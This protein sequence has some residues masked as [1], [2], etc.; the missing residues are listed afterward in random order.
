MTKNRAG[1]ATAPN[2]PFRHSEGNTIN[3]LIT[4]SSSLQHDEDEH[5]ESALDFKDDDLFHWL[6]LAAWLVSAWFSSSLNSLSV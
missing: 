3:V 1:F 5:Y 6:S 2:V 4:S